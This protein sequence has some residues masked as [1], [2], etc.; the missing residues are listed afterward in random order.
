[1][2]VRV[3][4]G[5]LASTRDKIVKSDAS[6]KDIEAAVVFLRDAERR[7]ESGQKVRSYLLNGLDQFSGSIKQTLNCFVHHIVT[8]S[9]EIICDEIV[10]SLINNRRN[11]MVM[12][13]IQKQAVDERLDELTDEAVKSAVA[14]AEYELSSEAELMKQ[15]QKDYL[16]VKFRLME[17]REQVYRDSIPKRRRSSLVRIKIEEV[18]KFQEM[19]R[20]LPVESSEMAL[21]SDLDSELPPHL[22]R[23]KKMTESAARKRVRQS[24]KARKKAQGKTRRGS[25]KPPPLLGKPLKLA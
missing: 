24:I 1:M 16:E 3:R 23:K 5:V 13:M 7:I 17:M 14:L 2:I 6:L 4:D 18:K 20:S 15:E 10:Y 12:D 21:D 22:L 19:M 11:S 8:K 9:H 25:R